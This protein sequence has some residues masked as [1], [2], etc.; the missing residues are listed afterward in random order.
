MPLLRRIWEF[1]GWLGSVLGVFLRTHAILTPALILSKATAQITKLLAF[2]LPLKV[3]LLVASPGVPRYFQFFID[4][5]YRNEWVVGLSVAAVACYLLTIVLDRLSDYCAEI[6]SANLL[7]KSSRLSVIG[8]QRSIAKRYFGEFSGLAANLLLVG[9]IFSVG[10]YVYSVLFLSLAVFIFA[11]IL[12]TWAVLKFV[13]LAEPVGFGGYIVKRTNGYLGYLEAVNFLAV[14]GFLVVDFLLFSGINILIA[15]LSFL[16]IRRL[17][18]SLTTVAG[19]AVQLSKQRHRIDP[20]IF[21]SE[22]HTRRQPRNQFK[23]NRYFG[24]Q[25]RQSRLAEILLAAGIGGIAEV[26]SIWFDASRPGSYLFDVYARDEAGAVVFRGVEHVFSSRHKQVQE[27]EALILEALGPSALHFA[28]VVHQYE[29]GDF[30]SRILDL[31]GFERISQRDWRARYQSELVARLW[32]VDPGE[33]LRLVFELSRPYLHERLK[34]ETLEVLDVAADTGPKRR[35]LEALRRRLPEVCEALG[36]LP[37]FPHNH[38]LA[39][40]GVFVD[41]HPHLKVIDWGRWSLEPIGVGVDAEAITGRAVTRWASVLSP[42]MPELEMAS[43][44]LLRLASR[45]HAFEELVLVRGRFNE[46]LQVGAEMLR[47]LDMHVTGADGTQ[48][49]RVREIN[50]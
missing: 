27:N 31:T 50:A 47:D 49:S 4:P 2:F 1:F 13:D 32:S 14:F 40:T 22:K 44:G 42:R 5:Q 21:L 11:Q 41:V 10:F 24:V 19:D 48:P 25:A 46:A 18:A 3:L 15:I 17:L 34:I 43:V 23:L 20:L 45:A 36:C 7:Q 29:I 28:D 30:Y 9:V 37:V 6:G 26:S 33:E 39:P 16:M 35:T 12:F 8:N 38:I